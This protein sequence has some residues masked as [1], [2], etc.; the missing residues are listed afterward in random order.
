MWNHYPAGSD[1]KLT[2]LKR[3]GGVRPDHPSL[4]WLS[5]MAQEYLW[6]ILP[7]RQREQWVLEDHFECPP[8]CSSALFSKPK[9]SLSTGGCLRA[10]VNEVAPTYTRSELTLWIAMYRVG[11]SNSVV[12]KTRHLCQSI[13]QVHWYMSSN[14]LRYFLKICS[15]FFFLKY[16]I[17]T[18]IR[19]WLQR[20]NANKYLP[21][22]L[23][24]CLYSRS[25]TVT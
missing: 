11:Y 13:W 15:N 7:H 23:T 21:E 12:A 19:K 10:E 17:C 16:L 4:P 9:F 1:A 18:I 22:N 24:A 8:G 3:K 2:L 25:E 14:C 5:V 6:H 20:Q